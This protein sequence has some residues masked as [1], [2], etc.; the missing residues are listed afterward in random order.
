MSSVRIACIVEGHGEV[1][2]LPVLLRR[3]AQIQNPGL[4]LDIVATLREK[5]SRLLQPGGIER[6]LSL[7]RQR[8]GA[9][10]AV[11][12]LL[13]ADT[14]CPAQLGPQLLQ[15]CRS[16]Q[17]DL[18]ISVVIAKVEFETWLLYAAHSLR[19]VRGLPANFSAPDDLETKRGAKE[20]FDHF[21]PKGYSETIDQAALTAQFDLDQARHSPSFDKL[22]RDFALLLQHSTQN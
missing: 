11:L 22:W 12:V 4:Y 3:I 17:G 18:A 6:S 15:R 8:V 7:A 19:G 9:N 2:A 16:T 5:K 14:N 13:D 1:D 10:G 20:W 21:M